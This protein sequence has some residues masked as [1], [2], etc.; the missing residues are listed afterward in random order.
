MWRTIISMILVA[1]AVVFFGFLFYRA[2][3]NERLFVRTRP[4][5]TEAPTVRVTTSF[6]P[7]Y[8]FASEIGG[9]LVEVTTITPAGTEPHDYEPSTPD[10]LEMQRSNLVILNG[11]QLEPWAE[12][13]AESLKGSKTTVVRVA[14]SLANQTFSENGKNIEDPHVWL[15]PVL[16]KE[17]VQLIAEK[18]IEVDPD[19]LSYYQQNA[20]NLEDKLTSLDT[21]FKQ[22]LQNCTQKNVVTS[23]A[24]LG[25]VA[26]EYG[27]TQIP[28][29]GISPDAEPSPKKLAELTQLLKANNTKY[30]FFETLT[31]PEIA[32][33]LAKETGAQILPFN[34]LE[35]LTAEE[36]Q[37]GMDYFSI[38]QDN[39]KNLQLAL[40]CHE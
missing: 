6:Y 13:V 10:I 33:T 30:I 1:S 21:Q 16:A 40:G 11:A 9:H 5:I 7:L 4:F 19:N 18:F 8:F 37:A 35:G 2:F 12:S 28:I 36:Q 20:Q 25:Y 39:I 34:P 29:A 24:A 3:T 31:S 26:K 22:A 15:D 32:K 38:Q 23:H 17:E 27:F 14:D